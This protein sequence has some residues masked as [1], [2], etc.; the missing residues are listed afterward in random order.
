MTYDRIHRAKLPAIAHDK[1]SLNFPGPNSIDSSGRQL[2]RELYPFRLNP[3]GKAHL[4]EQPDDQRHM[5]L[6]PHIRG[7]HAQNTR[8][9]V[10]L[11]V[12]EIAMDCWTCYPGGIEAAENSM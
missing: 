7:G 5:V 10:A 8:L 3:K 11:T 2:P 9:C 1:V 4:H 12:Q 6:I